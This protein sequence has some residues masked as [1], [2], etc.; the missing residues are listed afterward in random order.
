MIEQTL[1]ILVGTGFYVALLWLAQRNPRA[2]GIMLTFPAL[3]GIVLIMAAPATLADIAGAVLFMPVLNGMMWSSYLVG[4]PRLI[5]GGMPP[6]AASLLVLGIGAVVWI[7]AGA[8]IALN[9]WGV[10][11]TLQLPYLVAALVIGALFS[12]M[13]TFMPAE[14]SATAAG[15]MSPLDLFILHRNRIGLFVGILVAIA[16]VQLSGGPPAL[17]GVLAGLP[18]IAIFGLHAITS[19]E[20]MPVDRRLEIMDGMA[21]TVWLGPWIAVL[22]V[23]TYWRLLAALAEANT[24][25]TYLVLGTLALFACWALAI[26]LVWAMTSA[27]DRWGTVTAASRPRTP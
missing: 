16:L 12:R 23:A 11:P 18:L 17:L 1:K 13:R 4:A 14:P 19:Q 25:T 22:F 24:G 3:N 5:R 10:P 15:R 6:R 27:L 7:I 2:A 20:T 9:G 26:G 8:A 21:A